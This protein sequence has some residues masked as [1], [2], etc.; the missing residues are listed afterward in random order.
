MRPPRDI[1]R[2]IAAIGSKPKDPRA[3]AHRILERHERN[4]GT[5]TPIALQM[6]RDALSGNFRTAGR[7]NGAAVVPERQPGEDDA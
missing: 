3:W 5:V 1:Q 6:A 2:Q 4:D 7:R